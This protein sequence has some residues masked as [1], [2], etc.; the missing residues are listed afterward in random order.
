M[1]SLNSLH[2]DRRMFLLKETALAKCQREQVLWGGRWKLAFDQG[3]NLATLVA[4]NYSERETQLAAWNAIN[5]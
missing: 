3:W 4:F 2:R 1:Q 5:E